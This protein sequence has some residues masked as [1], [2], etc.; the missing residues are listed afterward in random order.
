M[1]DDAIAHLESFH[2]RGYGRNLAGRIRPE[3]M[4]QQRTPGVF[5]GAQ[6]NV[7]GLVYGSGAN[8]DGDFAGLE[9]RL[10]NLL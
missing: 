9:R 10:R 5:S 1:T 8:F 7:E 6:G 2:I 4:R 3:D